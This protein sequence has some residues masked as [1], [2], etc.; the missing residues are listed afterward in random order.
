M[1][2]LSELDIHQLDFRD[3][4]LIDQT[5][6]RLN[7]VLNYNPF[8][9]GL[10]KVELFKA[11]DII[12]EGARQ[13]KAGDGSSF[14]SGKMEEVG[15]TVGG[16]TLTNGNQYEPFQGKVIGTDNVVSPNAAGFFVQGDNNT[17][18]ASRNVTLI[19]SNNTVA[20]GVENVT[21]IGVS[22]LEITESNTVINGRGGLQYFDTDFDSA[23]VL[24][25]VSAS[26]EPMGMQRGTGQS[27]FIQS[28]Y[29]GMV[30]DLT[31]P[32]DTNTVV[33]VRYV[34]AD[35]PIFTLDVLGMTVTTLVPM[36][37]NTSPASGNT[38]FVND[39]DLEWY[40]VGGAALNGTGNL[41]FAITYIIP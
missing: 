28:I 26:P 13:G 12:F 35:E 1:F 21:A 32:Y 25:A 36:I 3:T 7:K 18:G 19:G 40:V 37:P 27:I 34:G 4:I 16:K 23:E 17:V 10:T 2:N 9:A 8:K 11:G 24:A 15:P 20:N 29:C 30:N 31:T 22:G 5:Y 33:A 39:T 41:Q 6:Y 38:V 14:G